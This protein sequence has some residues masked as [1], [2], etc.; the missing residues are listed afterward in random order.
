MPLYLLN[1]EFIISA[2]AYS[3][4]IKMNILFFVVKMM[5]YNKGIPK[6]KTF[7]YFQDDPT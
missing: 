5:N 1:Q 3:K 4:A 2:N 6:D 7:L